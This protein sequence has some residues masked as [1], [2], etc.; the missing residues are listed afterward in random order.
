MLL[1][2]YGQ[3]CFRIQE[4]IGN[5]MVTIVTDPF[6]KNS[7]L[8]IPRLEAD[9]LTI[10]YDHPSHNNIEAVKGSPYLIKAAGE[11]DIKGISIDGVDSYFEAKDD[12]AKDKNIIYRFELDSISLVHLGVLGQELDDKQLEKIASPDILLIP[13]GNEIAIGAKRA[14]EIIA[15]IEPRIVVPMYYKLPGLKDSLETVDKFIK[16]LGIK[17]RQEE[18]LKVSKKDLP[19]E[20]TELIILQI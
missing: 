12:K 11:Y 16:E 3:T 13:V 19:Q 6:D 18:K 15:R 1:N 2:W 14:V 8:K 9:I 10:S 4:K 20:E 17:P 7:G 5:E